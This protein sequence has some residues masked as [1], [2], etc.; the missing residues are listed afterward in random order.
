MLD[1]CLSWCTAPALH[2]SIDMRCSV[3]CFRG[4]KAG[5]QVYIS[6]GQLNNHKLALFYGFEIANNPYD[7]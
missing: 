4:A 3:R 7:K 5:E 6:Y 1:P 2:R